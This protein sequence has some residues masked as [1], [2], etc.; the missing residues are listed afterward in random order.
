[1]SSF[2]VFLLALLTILARAAHL[3]EATLLPLL[4]DELAGAVDPDPLDPPAPDRQGQL[5]RAITQAGREIAG[6]LDR[7]AQAVRESNLPPQHQEGESNPWN[8]KS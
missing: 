4:G 3:V 2:R 8:S 1:M 6:A 7:V 5:A